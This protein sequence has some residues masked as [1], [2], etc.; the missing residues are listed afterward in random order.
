MWLDNFKVPEWWAYSKAYVSRTPIHMARNILVEKMLE[1][2][3]DY[4]IMFDDD[5]RRLTE[6]TDD[7]HGRVEIEDIIKR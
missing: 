5:R 4:L 7:L 2:N 3:F 1:W 6:F